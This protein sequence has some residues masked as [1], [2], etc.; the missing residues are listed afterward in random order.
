VVSAHATTH[1]TAHAA[2]VMVAPAGSALPGAA[3]GHSRPGVSVF[4]ILDLERYRRAWGRVETI[5][6][7]RAAA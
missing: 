7:E 1:A 2:A 5:R 3:V 6:M 4:G